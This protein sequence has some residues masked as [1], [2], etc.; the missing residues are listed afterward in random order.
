VRTVSSETEEQSLQSR[1]Y[2][3]LWQQGTHDGEELQ[4]LARKKLAEATATTNGGSYD[5]RQ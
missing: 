2:S 5:A 3:T 1:S 4:R